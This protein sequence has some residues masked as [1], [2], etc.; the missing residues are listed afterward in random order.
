MVVKKSPSIFAF[1]KVKRGVKQG[2]LIISRYTETI[3]PRKEAM[4][5]LV[6]FAKANPT[7]EIKREPP[8][9]II[10]VKWCLPNITRVINAQQVKFRPNIPKVA[11]IDFC[12][13]SFSFSSAD[14][15]L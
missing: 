3:T 8:R 13:I 6:Y 12:S 4:A 15:V 9:K 1:G 11:A 7:A 2:Y 14:F 10:G 5:D